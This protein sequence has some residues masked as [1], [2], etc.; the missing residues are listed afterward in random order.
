[1][2]PNHTTTVLYKS[3]NTLW[4][5]GYENHYETSLAGSFQHSREY[6]NANAS[7]YLSRHTPLPQKYVLTRFLVWEKIR[8]TKC[9]RYLLMRSAVSA[10]Q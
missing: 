6:R 7:F 8:K 1:M 9:T 2:E 3:F 4:S 5:S 10:V